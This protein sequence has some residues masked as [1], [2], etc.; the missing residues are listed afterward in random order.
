MANSID[1]GGGTIKLSNK[2]R[3]QFV[4]IEPNKSSKH[5]SK[6]QS[7]GEAMQDMSNPQQPYKG[8]YTWL[9]S[10]KIMYNSNRKM[11]NVAVVS[12]QQH[13]V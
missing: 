6:Q 4:S 3:T 7:F 9:S 11:S 10:P 8:I 5:R 1:D 2:S 13:H 12:P